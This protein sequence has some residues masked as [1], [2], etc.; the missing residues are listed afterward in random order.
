MNVESEKNIDFLSTCV[1]NASRLGGGMAGVASPIHAGMIALGRDATFVSGT[2]PHKAV[3]NS[4]V[5]G[6]NGSGFARLPQSLFGSVVHIHGIWTPFE[7]G[8]FREARRRGASIV[9][10]P[11]G[12]LERWAFDHKRIKKRIAWWLY[13]KGVMQVADLIVVNSAQELRRM[14]ELG[15]AGPIATIPNG[16]ETSGFALAEERERTVLFFSRIDPKK[17]IPDLITAWSAITDHKGYKLRIHGHGEPAY[18]NLISKQISTVGNSTIEVGP[19]VFGSDRWEVFAKA[20]IY[21][22]PSY[23]EN[24][25]I[26]VAEALMAGL[27]VITTKATPW[28]ELGDLGLGWIIDNNVEQLRGALTQAID[29]DRET[30]SRMSM[31]AHLYAS[32]RFGWDNIVEQYAETYEWLLHPSRIAPDWVDPGS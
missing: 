22:L 7:Y 32:Q 9:V 16:V 26:T 21:V 25:G 1:R 19:P 6:T 23:S 17:G 10:S 2:V 27:P 18:M 28:G 4:Y 15:L 31:E 5:V 8:A 24:F 30:R 12:A 14:R 20:A 29:L 13:Q 11:H 3:E